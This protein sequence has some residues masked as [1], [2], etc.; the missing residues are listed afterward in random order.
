MFIDEAIHD[1]I[2]EERI[3]IPPGLARSVFAVP[4][5]GSAAAVTTILLGFSTDPVARWVYPTPVT[6]MAWFPAF[7]RGFAGK[8][9]EHGSAYSTADLCG[10]ALWLPPDAQPDEDALM[11]LFQNSTTEE[12]RKDL[13]PVFEAMGSYHPEEPHWYLPM[14]GVD[15]PMQG[16]GL[17]SQLMQYALERVDADGLAAYLES[18]NPRNIPLYE[19]F[20]F[21]V[22]GEIAIGSAPP[23]FPMLRQP[24]LRTFS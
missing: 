19:R 24:V 8:A 21:E 23:L 7:I 10:A 4:T 6:Y 9:F 5:S 22:I 3:E 12:V 20:G 17:G 18:S 13:F 11:E 15:T 14:I 2:T 16:N 1:A